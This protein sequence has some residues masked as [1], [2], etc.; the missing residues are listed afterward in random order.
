MSPRHTASLTCAL[1]VTALT[2]A[3]LSAGDAQTPQQRPVFRSGAIFVNVDAYPRKDG[4]IVD[5]LIRTDFEIFEDGKPQAV[6]EFEFVRVAPTTPDEDR[7]DPRS[8]EESNREAADPHN[9][10]FV[11]YLDLY[12]VTLEGSRFARA[13]IIE[14]LSRSIGPRDLFGVMTPDMPASAITFAR[15]TETLE[16]DLR[17]YWG[18]GEGN[19]R[20]TI[21][22]EPAEARLSQC[23]GIRS[24]NG[25][26]LITAYRRDKTFRS[27]EQMVAR[28]GN[29]RDERKHILYVSEGWRLTPAAPLGASPSKS[30]SIP[31]I[32]VGPGGKL[33][34]GPNGSTSGEHDRAWCNSQALTLFSIDYE[35]RF[36]A[37][38]DWA[39]Q[40]N[41]AF[42][43]IDVGGLRTYNVPAGETLGGKAFLRQA[44]E[45]R[46]AI[47]DRLNMLQDLASA[48]DG[49]AIVNTNDLAGGVRKISDDLSAYYLLGYYSN[50]TAADGKFRRIDVKV[51]T[52]GVK[53]SAR[54][55]YL[56]PT[57]AVKKA[58]EEAASKPVR[59]ETAVDRELA[60]LARLRTDFRLF[61]AGVVSSSSLEV[62]VEIASNEFATGRWA[63]GG[64]VRVEVI[65]KDGNA[66]PVTAE[67]KLES[68]ARGVLLK[69]P[70]PVPA[71]GTWRIR[72]RIDGGGES[73]DDEIEIPAAASA[74]IGDPTVFR[75]NPGPRAPLSPVADFKFFRTERMHVEWAL[76]K[77]LDARTARLLNRRGE[78]LAVPVA[79]TERTDG[80]RLVLA[81][82][83]TLAPLADGDYVIEVTASA[84]GAKIQKL[85][86]F[87]VVR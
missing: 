71:A 24:T 38:A 75:A 81:A 33:V 21:V 49:R 47:V 14:F 3:A 1:T 36:R 2:V 22:R 62:V 45:Y 56:G 65:S 17:S 78:P 83:L 87:R 6:E 16:A 48:T 23:T 12:S 4:K 69:L 37:L 68:G 39:T 9:R 79:L 72:S 34:M 19:R 50:N 77:A 5:N 52:P 84:G 86:A 57:A 85:L 54:R 32:G 15:R 80:D 82:D 42:Y 27:L 30:P 40:M 35:Q 11:V 7:R 51:K 74:I 10:V 20:T 67:A 18:L 76:A 66:K 41:V 58:E 70:V 8:I 64:T 25:D 60:R 59:E 13:P 29:L 28:L 43:P 31:T 55:G 44:E 53:V 73:L 61:T 26:G 46:Q 63:N